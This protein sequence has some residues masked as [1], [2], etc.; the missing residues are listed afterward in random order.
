MFLQGKPDVRLAFIQFVLS[1]LVSGDSAVIRQIL[2]LKGKGLLCI[3]SKIGIIS[4]YF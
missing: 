3:T 2:E 1:F 4:T